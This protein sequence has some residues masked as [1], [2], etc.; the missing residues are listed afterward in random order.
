[1]ILNEAGGEQ[2]VSLSLASEPTSEVTLNF[3]SND[4]S[5]GRVSKSQL[6]FTQ[7]NWNIP[8][9]FTVSSV[10]DLIQDGPTD[11][12]VEF[13]SPV[14]ADTDYASLL[15]KSVFATTKDNDTP[16][17]SVL[18]D[19]Q[20]HPVIV[21]EY[22]SSQELEIV[23]N[24][25]PVETVTISIGSRDNSE[26]VTSTP[27]V[28]F[29]PDNWNISQ[30]VI[31]N[32][33]DDNNFDNHQNVQFSINVNSPDPNYNGIGVNDIRAICIDNEFREIFATPSTSAGV[34]AAKT[35]EQGRG[36][37]IDVLLTT[38]P[39]DLVFLPYASSDNS[40]GVVSGSQLIFTPENWDSPQRIWITGVDDDLK[41]GDQSY[42]L[43]FGE[44]TSDDFGYRRERPDDMN[45][46][47]LDDD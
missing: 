14:S 25:E 2:V 20:N 28:Q 12:A 30:T 11:W 33:V 15:I 42:Q 27:V 5:E 39:S 6:V 40:E 21:N 16:G 36:A 19:T 17:V 23:L 31:I 34:G 8:Q 13:A 4:P 22:G 3:S 32:G 38:Q 9:E 10:D 41:D 47:N 35:S 37:F 24:S 44:A 43:Q 7:D 45:L 18:P 1:M 46:I 29:T 26:A